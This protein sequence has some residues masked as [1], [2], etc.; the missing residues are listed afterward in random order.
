MKAPIIQIG[1][2]FF[3]CKSITKATELAKLLSELVRVESHHSSDYRKFWYEEIS[4]DD[5]PM[6]IMLKVSEE[7]RKKPARLGLPAP[8]RGAI[9]CN[10]GRGTVLPGE[11]CPSCNTP[12]HAIL[13]ARQS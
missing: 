1:S 5:N 8:R 2:R 11:L 10:C 3:A 7:V 12:F 4:D 13:E 9:R 6:D